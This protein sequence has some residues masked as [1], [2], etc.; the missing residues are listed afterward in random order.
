MPTPKSIL[1]GDKAAKSA[2]SHSMQSVTFD[3]S[4]AIPDVV[5]EKTQ[6]LHPT[7]FTL[8]VHS[9]PG[10]IPAN[11]AVMYRLLQGVGNNRATEITRLEQAVVDAQTEAD[12][13][14][15]ERDARDLRRANPTFTDRLKKMSPF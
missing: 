12:N 11:D 3:K 2:S 15:A 6:L 1:K 9:A 4:V 13:C 14:Q 10:T 5:K 7:H 8:N